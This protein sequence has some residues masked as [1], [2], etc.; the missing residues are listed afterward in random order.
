MP[1]HRWREVGDVKFIETTANN[2]DGAIA[3][4]ELHIERP[5]GEFISLCWPGTVEKTGPNG[6]AMRF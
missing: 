4:F 1:N 6:E 5:G 3:E 2:W